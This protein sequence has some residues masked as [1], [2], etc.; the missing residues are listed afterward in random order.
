VLSV[1]G[2]KWLRTRNQSVV[3]T[4]RLPHD[5]SQYLSEEAKR[6]N[7]TASSFIT[8]ILQSYKNKYQLMEKLGS[9]AIRPTSMSH[10]L[11]SIDERKIPEIADSIAS[12]FLVLVSNLM[13]QEETNWFEWG[14]I[15][16]LPSINWY[17]CLK[18][19][20]GCMI[21]HSMGRNWTIFLKC[22]FNSLI[23]KY[24]GE[25]PF[26]EVDRDTIILRPKKNHIGSN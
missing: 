10:F 25:K 15:D 22:F 11:N 6:S 14:V 9:M 21:T 20:R 26:V 18:S 8:S 1:T 17:K 3:K 13:A 24:P 19:S 12:D 23:A 2:E 7:Q 5:L 16:F 4:I